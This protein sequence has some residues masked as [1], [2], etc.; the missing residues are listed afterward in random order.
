[1]RTYHP[2]Q[3]GSI[4]LCPRFKADKSED[5]IYA[6]EGRMLHKI[7]S[8]GGDVNDLTERQNE[9]I[10]ICRNYEA[11]LVEKHSAEKIKK[12]ES[13]EVYL[14]PDVRLRG[15]MDLMLKIDDDNYEVT[16]WKT[17]EGEVAPAK[18]NLQTMA[19]ALMIFLQFNPK[20]KVKTTL[21]SPLAPTIYTEHTWEASDVP[22]LRS[23][24]EAI[25]AR[26]EDAMN[27][28]KL[29]WSACRYC[30]DKANCAE[31]AQVIFRADDTF[32][33]ESTGLILRPETGLTPEIRGKR[34]RLAGMLED[35]AK[36]IKRDNVQAVLENG[37]Y[38]EGYKLTKRR[39]HMS[40]Q[41]TASAFAMLRSA[42]YQD[43]ILLASS[44][45]KP[46]ALVA[47]IKATEKGKDEDILAKIKNIL[48]GNIMES[49]PI[50]YLKRERKRKEYED[51]TKEQD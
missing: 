15:T 35:L 7:L 10:T 23:C 11:R 49:D 20:R 4:Q 36:Q 16:D 41:N 42:G 2:S 33:A 12:E 47:A 31:M 32:T 50:C 6:Q 28:P 37:E 44:E 9:I 29:N 5:S 14:S 38:V 30:A 43:D 13:L 40:V 45:L 1:M 8:D 48:E 24:V 21:V 26:S 22:F 17:G 18:D 46:T 3:L 27:K 39:G 34:H 25:I 19:Y 51:G